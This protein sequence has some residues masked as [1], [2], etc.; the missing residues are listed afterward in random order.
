MIPVSKYVDQ[1]V[2]VFGLGRSGIASVRA[3]V[4]GGAEVIAWDDRAD[5]REQAGEQGLALSDVYDLDWSTVAA[6]VLSPGIPLTHPEP[7]PVVELATAAGCP[8]VG[9]MELFAH[10]RSALNIKNPVIAITGTNGKSTTTALIGHILDA[11]GRPAAVGGNIGRPV[12][13][14]DLLADNGIYVLEMS[15]YQIDLTETF[16]ADVAVLL[17]ITPDHLD[18]HGSME[19]YVRIKRRL[20][21]RQG[22]NDSAVVGIDDPEC[23]RIHAGLSARGVQTVIPFSA[24]RT[25]VKGVYVDKGQLYDGTRGAITQVADLASNPAFVGIHNWQNAAAAVASIG[26]LG[27]DGDRVTQG[28]QSFP[29]L[30]HRQEQIAIVDG[31]RFVNDSKATNPESAARALA[32]YDKIY[33][34]AGGRAKEGELDPLDPYLERVAKAY[35]IGAAENQLAE[36]LDRRADYE[37]S[38]TLDVAVASAVRDAVADGGQDPVVLL[39]PACASFDQFSDFEARGDTFRELVAALKPAANGNG[40][41]GG[42]AAGGRAG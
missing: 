5:R 20:L 35:L 4:A 17:N 26:A 16:N 30:A 40:I 37:R 38:Q 23:A 24:E 7:H 14:L 9:D 3:L 41:P 42:A 21:E 6:L 34:I 12:L 8:V 11:V 2:A 32:C 10:A 22:S 15:S 18:R 31:V 33:W 27:I 25:V 28:L 39:S 29:G 19:N 36:F 13:D 1:K